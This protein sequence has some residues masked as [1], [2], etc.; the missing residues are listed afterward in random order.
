MIEKLTHVPIVVSDQDRALRF[1]TEVLGFE[2]RA[3]YQNPWQPSLVDGRPEG[4]G[5]RDDPLPRQVPTG[6]AGA[7]GGG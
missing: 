2:K 5:R 1:Y 6:S 3:D 4:S 7:P